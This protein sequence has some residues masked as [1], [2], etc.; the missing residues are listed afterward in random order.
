MR[1]KD[2]ISAKY[3]PLATTSTPFTPKADVVGRGEMPGGKDAS[4]MMYTQVSKLT[5]DQCDAAHDEIFERLPPT[6]TI[7]FGKCLVLHASNFEHHQ[8]R[9]ERILKTSVF[10]DR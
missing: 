6:G 7:C 10:L 1:L 3:V 4:V 5:K 2:P 8:I 9:I